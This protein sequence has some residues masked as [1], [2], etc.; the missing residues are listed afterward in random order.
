MGHGRVRDG[1]LLGLWEAILRKLP[2][3]EPLESGNANWSFSCKVA[4]RSW[5]RHL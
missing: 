1:F 2:S 3:G 4:C 5:L